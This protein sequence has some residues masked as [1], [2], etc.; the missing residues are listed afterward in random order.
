M[1]NIHANS[2]ININKKGIVDFALWF[3]KFRHRNDSDK[4][5]T[6]RFHDS[7]LIHSNEKNEEKEHDMR[8]SV[9]SRATTLEPIAP[10]ELIKAQNKKENSNK[11]DS[12]SPITNNIKKVV[13][14]TVE[15]LSIKT[16]KSKNS[17]NKALRREVLAYT[18]DGIAQSIERGNKY[19]SSNN[20][21]IDSLPEKKFYPI[22]INERDN[23]EYNVNS[24]DV[25][26][27]HNFRLLYGKSSQSNILE[28][29]KKSAHGEIHLFTDYGPLVF[30][31]IRQSILGL[32]DK[33]YINSIIPSTQKERRDVLDAKYGEGKSGA[34][35]YF[36]HDSKY[37]VKTISK[38]EASFLIDIL[39][40]YVR[41]LSENPNTVINRFIALHSCKMYNL[42][43]YFV[44]M[45]NVFLANLQ[46]HEKYDLKGSY[47]DRSTKH[48][49]VNSGKVMKDLDLKKFIILSNENRIKIIKQM[50]I[51]T[52]FLA[53]QNIMDYSLLLGIYY[54]KISQQNPLTSYKLKNNDENKLKK[55]K[56][57]A[58]L[59][60]NYAGGV[61]AQVIEGPGIY[62]M[63]IIDILQKYNLRKKFEHYCK[64][65][66]LRKDGKG[67][68]CVEPQYYQMRYMNYMK[69]IM[70][71]D[72]DFYKQLDI[73]LK[74]FKKHNFYCYPPSNIIDDTLTEIRNSRAS[75]LN[76]FKNY[77]DDSNE[78]IND[79]D[80]KEENTISYRPKSLIEQ[81]KNI[82]IIDEDHS[83]DLSTEV[84]ST[85]GLLDDDDDE[86]EDIKEDI[87]EENKD[88][89]NTFIIEIEDANSHTNT[90]TNNGY[91]SPQ[92]PPEP[93]PISNSNYI[94][95]TTSGVSINAIN[96]ILGNN[97][98]F[99]K[100]YSSGI[101]Y[102]TT[103]NNRDSIINTTTKKSSHNRG[104]SIV[105]DE[106]SFNDNDNENIENEPTITATITE[107]EKSNVQ[108]PL[109]LPMLSGF[110][111]SK[112]ITKSL[113]DTKKQSSVSFL[114]TSIT[115]LPANATT[116]T[117]TTTTTM[118][119]TTINPSISM[120]THRM[121]SFTRSIT[122][123]SIVD[124][125]N[126]SK[127]LSTNE[128][129]DNTIHEKQEN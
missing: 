103:N 85:Q 87:K 57:N 117:T 12:N 23:F 94:N 2:Q 32:T 114:T 109:P 127:T 17:I 70:I 8:F 56:T 28:E 53:S 74:K 125:I 107:F 18:T 41:H 14:G 99:N 62:Y 61:R 3:K 119:M 33:E 43:I 80:K 100:D 96:K 73:P 108:P 30:R 113:L 34:F 38:E 101:Q 97:L 126:E 106:Y 67:I 16:T 98:S 26:I 110:G 25:I 76:L 55:Q 128:I 71:T 115:P 66:I 104:I 40:N 27:K 54:M 75:T 63:G 35:F 69:S 129:D 90:N 37:L 58:N 50:E 9:V 11:N 31:Y 15:R 81:N 7:F 84:E 21:D 95:R 86:E 45:E 10:D 77:D 24:F 88:R 64:K 79:N 47:I 120:A 39:P 22:S 83:I 105:A 82:G 42:T 93:S 52:K 89:K 118:N 6:K 116:T 92:E 91:G 102:T 20:L 4:K 29:E 72:Y 59:M 51:D 122:D 68:S 49:H 48:T 111:K 123:E 19:A 44:V 65:I 112:S 1:K 36:T 5:K 78:I 60:T 121:D 124:N 13:K 46:P